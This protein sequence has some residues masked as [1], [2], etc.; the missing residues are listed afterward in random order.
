MPTILRLN[1]SGGGEIWLNSKD[2]AALRAAGWSYGGVLYDG[3]PYEMRTALPLDA[4]RDEFERLTGFDGFERGCDCCGPP[5]RFY[6]E[7]EE[8]E[9]PEELTPGAIRFSMLDLS[10]PPPPVLTDPGAIRFSL[11]VLD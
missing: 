6:E 11:L 9:E 3:S 4:A 7:E 10:D 5:F 2:L 8:S 1:N